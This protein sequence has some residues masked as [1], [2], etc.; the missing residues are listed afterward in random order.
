MSPHIANV[1][2]KSQLSL[3]STK[4]RH[5]IRILSS[6]TSVTGTFSD[7]FRY[8]LSVIFRMRRF[9]SDDSA[10]AGLWFWVAATE[11]GR[12]WASGRHADSVSE[13]YSANIVFAPHPP[14]SAWRKSETLRAWPF[15]SSVVFVRQFEDNFLHLLLGFTRTMGYCGV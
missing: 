7:V 13:S 12:S 10:S 2:L 14:S 3:L 6:Y 9:P 11:P 1:T 15:A 5:A 8:D 4:H